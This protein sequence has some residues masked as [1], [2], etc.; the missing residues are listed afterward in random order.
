MKEP[1]PFK[2]VAFQYDRGIAKTVELLQRHGIETFESCEGGRGHAYPEPIVCFHGGPDQGWKAL[3][4]CLQHGLPV[5][6]LRRF[7]NVL[8][9]HE[10][11]GPHWALVFRQRPG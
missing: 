11:T 4:V 6:E 3:H 1:R 2:R 8:E 7:W 9:G 5:S 10:P